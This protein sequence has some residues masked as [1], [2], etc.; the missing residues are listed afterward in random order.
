MGSKTVRS[1][2]ACSTAL[3]ESCRVGS[4][5]R[6]LIWS[7][8]C[9]RNKMNASAL[10][11]MSSTPL[12]S[13]IKWIKRKLAIS[14]TNWEIAITRWTRSLGLNSKGK[15]RSSHSSRTILKPS[16]EVL[17]AGSSKKNWRVQLKKLLF[18]AKWARFQMQWGT[19]STDSR[20]NRF[21]LQTRSAKWSKSR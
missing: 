19:K 14:K 5:L 12:I 1:L 13:K 10:L 18:V 21:K 9:W 17:T 3:M 6:S 8:G 16:S 20:M 2:G 4:R 7:I 11:T 15:I